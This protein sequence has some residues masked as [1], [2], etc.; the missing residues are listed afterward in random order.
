[1]I[2]SSPSTSSPSLSPTAP[3]PSADFQ[4]PPSSLPRR[5]R[6]SQAQREAFLDLFDHGPLSAKAF[7]AAHA[8]EY[9]T[10][11]LWLRKR[12]RLQARP[13]SNAHGADCSVPPQWIE[14]VLPPR[15]SES[16]GRCCLDFP[17]GIKL[18]LSH[19][20]QLP[21]AARLLALLCSAND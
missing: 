10:F 18:T 1:M 19:P 13:S 3:L 9:A 2:A 20:A 14:A 4:G 15:P 8:I 16:D 21:L 5:A 7:A 17:H 6:F 12:R 11:A